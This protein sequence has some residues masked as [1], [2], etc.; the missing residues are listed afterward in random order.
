MNLKYCQGHILLKMER[1]KKVN[2]LSIVLGLSG[3]ILVVSG[4]L[5]TSLIPV[6]IGA[7]FFVLVWVC[8]LFFKK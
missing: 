4:V 6:G 2:I 7:V 8:Q 1:K 3:V 5:L